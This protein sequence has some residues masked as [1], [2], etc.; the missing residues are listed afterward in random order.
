MGSA[1]IYKN[2]K[3]NYGYYER[4]NKKIGHNFVQNEKS[5]ITA[6]ANLIETFQIN[7][8]HRILPTVHFGAPL[9]QAHKLFR[10]IISTQNDPKGIAIDYTQRA[11]PFP[12]QINLEDPNNTFYCP[13]LLTHFKNKWEIIYFIPN[14][15]NEIEVVH[16]TKLPDILQQMA[17]DESLLHMNSHIIINA[18]LIHV[19]RTHPH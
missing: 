16:N 19:P 6:A 5:A 14:E 13:I 9:F 18:Q 2:K 7:Y 12:S 10:T 15:T 1:I 8:Q 4:L 17:N 3:N 11:T